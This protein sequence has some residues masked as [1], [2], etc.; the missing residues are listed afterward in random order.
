VHAKVIISKLDPLQICTNDMAKCVINLHNSNQIKI[1][2]P[3]EQISTTH[4]TKL[5]S[6]QL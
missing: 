3:S 4:I 5:S 6:H 2:E 1:S